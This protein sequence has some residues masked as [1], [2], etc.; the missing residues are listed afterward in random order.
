MGLTISYIC[1]AERKNMRNRTEARDRL[2]REIMNPSPGYFAAKS[3]RS[4]RAMQVQRLVPALADAD[5]RFRIS[6]ASVDQAA[7]API[8]RHES[9]EAQIW[10]FVWVLRDIPS[11]L[12]AKEARTAPESW[13]QLRRRW[14]L[15]L[16]LPSWAGDPGWWR[17]PAGRAFEGDAD[18]IVHP[19]HRTVGWTEKGLKDRFIRFGLSPAERR[20]RN[21]CGGLPEGDEHGMR[22][23]YPDAPALAGP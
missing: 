16:D 8:S 13:E 19:C 5:T 17:H 11:T 18:F 3:N 23:F 9:D 4:E 10:H 20:N 15:L 21:V 12:N 22:L 7:S 2:T 6:L 1:D 14:Q